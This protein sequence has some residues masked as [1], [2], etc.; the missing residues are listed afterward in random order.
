MI[1]ALCYKNICHFILLGVKTSVADWDKDKD[2]LLYWPI[3]SSLDHTTLC[4]LQ[5][6]TYDFLCFSGGRYSTGGPVWA[7][8]AA[9]RPTTNRHYHDWPVLAQSSHYPYPAWVCAY[10]LFNTHTFPLIHVIVSAFFHRCI[11]CR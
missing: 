5:G 4:Y 6:S 2:R 9:G 3:T 8:G 11:V 10:I 7:L 1:I